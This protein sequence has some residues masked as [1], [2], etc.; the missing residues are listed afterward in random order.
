M[1][2]GTQTSQLT[3]LAWTVTHYSGCAGDQGPLSAVK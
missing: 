2:G 1:N 3:H